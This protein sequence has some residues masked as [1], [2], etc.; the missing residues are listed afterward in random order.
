MFLLIIYLFCLVSNFVILT[1]RQDASATY[2]LSR[3]VE[4]FTLA[5]VEHQQAETL[6]G[7]VSAL[8]IVD[9]H[10]RADLFK[11]IHTDLPRN[12]FYTDALAE[13]K[14]EFGGNN[15]WIESNAPL[16][17]RGV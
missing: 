4:L 7:S 13:Q 10:T 17:Q 11:Y 8:E 2:Q 9:L 15:A 1:L 14:E 16:L 5:S 3:Q 12:L 6:D